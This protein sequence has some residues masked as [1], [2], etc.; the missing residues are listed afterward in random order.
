MSLQCCLGGGED[1]DLT[2]RSVKAGYRGEYVKDAVLLHN[3][4]S[5]KTWRKFLKKMFY[6][7]Q[8]GASLA[9]R[10]NGMLFQRAS[11]SA[12]TNAKFKDPMEIVIFMLKIP[13]L[14]FSFMINPWN[15]SRYCKEKFTTHNV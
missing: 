9:Y 6:N 5:I 8:V 13:A 12:Y 4:N 2:I 7:Y 14:I 15:D 11:S 1:Y 3:Q 10:K